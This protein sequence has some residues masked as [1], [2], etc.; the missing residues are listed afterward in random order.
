MCE[1][2]GSALRQISWFLVLRQDIQITCFSFERVSLDRDEVNAGHAGRGELGAG[3]LQLPEALLRVFTMLRGQ[4]HLEWG[5]AITV[6]TSLILLGQRAELFRR[7]P[8]RPGG[9][10]QLTFLQQS[11]ARWDRTAT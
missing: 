8:R 9:G 10:N 2:G 1:S 7:Q 11:G 6:S 3:S 4:T 5:N